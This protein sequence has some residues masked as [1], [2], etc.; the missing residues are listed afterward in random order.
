MT[1]NRRACR[2]ALDRRLRTEESRSR[3][4]RDRRLEPRAA[5]TGRLRGTAPRPLASL[6]AH[7]DDARASCCRTC[8]STRSTSTGGVCSLLFEHNPRNGVLQ[9]TSG[10]GLDA[11][12]PI[13]G[14]RRPTKRRSSPTRSRAD[15]DARR[16]RRS[17]RCRISRRGSAR[18]AALLLPLVRGDGAR[19][20]ARGRLRRAAGAGRRRRRRRAESPTPS[21]RRSSCSASARATSCSAI[22]AR[23]S[24]SSPRACRRR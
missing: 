4:P 21:S 6:L 23:C 10:F 15:A 8:T 22:S 5:R 24:T 20:P 13:R 9:A 1:Y 14:C 12:R 11:L 16:R 17:R 7:S 18:R 19:R 3:D 2:A